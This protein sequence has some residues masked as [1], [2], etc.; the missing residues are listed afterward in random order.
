MIILLFL[1]LL[2][3][4]EVVVSSFEPFASDFKGGGV[5]GLRFLHLGGYLENEH[6]DLEDLV[7]SYCFKVEIPVSS[8][9]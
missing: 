2:K 6:P 3:C 1:T 5:G 4:L 9:L 8:Y 7:V